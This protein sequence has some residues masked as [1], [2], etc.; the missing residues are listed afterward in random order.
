[1]IRQNT[2]WIALGTS[3]RGLRASPAATPTSSVP[4]KENPATMNTDTMASIPPWKGASLTTQLLKPGDVPP[5]MPAIMAR[6][7]TRKTTTVTTLMADSQNSP[8]PKAR[9]D[10][11]L[12]VV[13]SA[14]NSAAQIHEGTPGSQ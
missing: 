1:M 3:R 6:P 13:S 5:M 14:R 12:S 7:A 8:S 11:A 9:A 10:R 4:W 2:V